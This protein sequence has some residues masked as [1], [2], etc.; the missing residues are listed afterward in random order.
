M[1]VYAVFITD[2]TN[3]D[4]FQG[5][6]RLA[7]DALQNLFC[8]PRDVIISDMYLARSEASLRTTRAGSRVF[9]DANSIFSFNF[10]CVC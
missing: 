3:Q 1:S 10:N 5:Q 6:S 8:R 9:F 4:V 7:I 2:N